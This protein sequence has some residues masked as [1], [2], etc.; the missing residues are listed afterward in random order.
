MIFLA[1]AQWMVQTQAP[2]GRLLFP[3]LPAMAPLVVIGWMQ[4][5]LPAARRT[6]SRV[7]ALGLFGIASAAAFLWLAPAYAG[8]VRLNESEAAAIPARVDIRFDDSLMLL[9][10]SVRP[11][12]VDPRGAL[13]VDLY[14]RA[15][16]PMDTDY[17]LNLAALDENF[18]VVG[19][20][21]TYPGHG[22]LPTRMMAAGEVFR[23]TYWLP[24]GAPT[25]SVQV[26][27]YERESQQN[28]DAFDPAGNEITPIVN[29]FAFPK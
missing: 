20:R 2:H 11:H 25:G 7:I 9:G 16:K 3:A 22:L 1:L 13:Q 12:P 8:P 10:S 4:L 6:A 14:W 15:L 26:S 29:K 5:L 24:A 23:D 18:R 17:S 27:V 28:L 19:S 21:N